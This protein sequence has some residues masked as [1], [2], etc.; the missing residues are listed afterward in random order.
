MTMMPKEFECKGECQDRFIESIVFGCN[1]CI[2]KVAI[3][4]SKEEK[5][6]IIDILYISRAY[7]KK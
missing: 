3:S 1:N 6:K 2:K 7:G 4:L 5:D